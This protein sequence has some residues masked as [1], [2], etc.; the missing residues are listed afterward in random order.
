MKVREPSDRQACSLTITGS[1]SLSFPAFSSAKTIYAVINFVRLAG[2]RRTAGSRDA[3]TL[4]VWKS[5]RVNARASTLGGVGIGVS[6]RTGTAANTAHRSKQT[7]GR[8][9]MD[10]YLRR[11]VGEV[12][13]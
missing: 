11:N 6:A 8:N 7:R 12:Y 2:S 4:P 1:S 3:S 10:R 5:M 9:M 13:R